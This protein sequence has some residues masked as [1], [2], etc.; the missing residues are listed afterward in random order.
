M[1]GV[2]VVCCGLLLGAVVWREVPVRASA[3]AGVGGVGWDRAGAARYLD[4]REVWWQQWAPAKREQGTV[5]ISCHTTVPYAMARPGL[6]RALGEEGMTATEKAMRAS[7]D[8]RVSRWAEMTPFY[9]DE[10]NG[11]GKNGGI[12]RDRGGDECGDPGEL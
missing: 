11:A 7:V 10:R 1:R 9:S 2:V 4:E 3:A 8:L 5:C 6:G 12:S